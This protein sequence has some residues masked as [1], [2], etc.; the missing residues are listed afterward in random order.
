M[1]KYMIN[2]METSKDIEPITDF[3]YVQDSVKNAA[4]FVIAEDYVKA[5]WILGRLYTFCEQKSQFY[6]ESK[7]KEDVYLRDMLNATI[8]TPKV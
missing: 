5:A 7:E 3:E 6:K 2:G 4:T 8:Y 1:N